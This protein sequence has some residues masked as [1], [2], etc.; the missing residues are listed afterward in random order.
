MSLDN[1]IARSLAMT[2]RAWERHANPLSFYTRVPIL[3]LAALVI[4]MRPVL[5][6]W[7]LVPLAALLVWADLNPR[8]FPPPAHHDAYATRAV[9]GERLYLARHT[10]PIPAHQSRAAMVLMVIGFSGLPV[11]A[12]GLYVLDPFATLLGLAL[13]M[14]GKLWFLDRMVWLHE[15]MRGQTVE[16]ETNLVT[17][18]S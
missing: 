10:A 2:D 17:D 18:P 13:A 3:P 8:A 14:G 15:E 4:Y 16:A 7:C 12:Y 1:T 5:G 6:L 11:L 9:L